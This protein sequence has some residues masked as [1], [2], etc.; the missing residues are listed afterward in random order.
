MTLEN[1]APG[2]QLRSRSISY[3]KIDHAYRQKKSR[4]WPSR[5]KLLVLKDEQPGETLR[6]P[7]TGKAR[8]KAKKGPS[9]RRLRYS[10]RSARSWEAAKLVTT[11][12]SARL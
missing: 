9:E 10:V 6:I 5:R 7:L 12:S 1:D 4:S 11:S 8:R 2:A 3:D